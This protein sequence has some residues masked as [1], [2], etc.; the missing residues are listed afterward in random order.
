VIETSES[1]SLL[2]FAVQLARE[3]GAITLTYFKGSFNVERKADNSLVT[4]VDREVEA[5]LRGKIEEAFPDDAIVGEEEND[6]RGSSGRR[7]I[8]DPIDRNY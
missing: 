4:T 2:N 1:K 5:F 3:A 8:I 6:R 7:W